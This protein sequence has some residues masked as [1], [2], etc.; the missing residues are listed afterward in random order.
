MLT[1]LKLPAGEPLVALVACLAVAQAAGLLLIV[2]W[3]TNIMEYQR[4]VIRWL[5]VECQ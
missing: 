3:Q 2:V 1:A 5:W 4:E